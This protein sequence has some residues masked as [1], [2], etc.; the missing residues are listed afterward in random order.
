MGEDIQTLEQEYC[1]PLDPALVHAIYLDF[2]GHADGLQQT[3]ELLDGLKQAAATEQLT[4]FDPSGSSGDAVRSSPSKQGSDDLDSNAETWTSQTTVTDYTGLSNDIAALGLRSPDGSSSEESLN[5][6]YFTDTKQF[7]T[8][9]KELL[10][11]ETFPTLRPELVA[12]T[13]K[14]CNG[15]FGKATDE[16]LN[17]VYFEDARASPTEET[18]VAKGID[19]FSEEHHVPQRKKKKGKQKKHKQ[20]CSAYDTSPTSGSEADPCPTPPTNKWKDSGRDVEFITSRIN[21][22]TKVVSSMYHHN[23]ASLAATI[24]AAIKKDMALHEKDEPDAALVQPAIELTADF[25]KVDLEYA[26]SI[27]RLASPSTANAHELAKALTVYPSL[28]PNSQADLKLVPHYAPANLSDSTSEPTNL[29]ILPSTAVPRSTAS[30]AAARSSAFTQA[31][32]AYRRGKSDHLMKAAAGYYSQL[33]R[34]YTSNLHASSESDADALVS[35]QSTS[36]TLDLHGVSVPSA[37]RIAKERTLAWW[38]GLG[39]ARIPGGGRRGVG[40]GYRI[41]TGLGRHSEGG[42]GKLG[43]AVVKSLVGEGWKV[44]VGSGELVVWGLARRR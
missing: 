44:E 35:S 25:P 30:L 18:V 27:V 6:G 17:H 5:G 3:K 36:T 4:E 22:P 10:L 20:K 38:D 14:K 37:T 15:D 41:V 12:Y 24:L 21:L 31:S 28:K 19:A 32:A 13:L 42:R 8:Q 23:G 2:A 33:A 40:D 16:L 9:T 7:D 29:P 11:A 43:P 34:D 1:P 26:I 39:E